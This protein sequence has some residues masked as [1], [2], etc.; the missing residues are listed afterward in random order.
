MLRGYVV[1]KFVKTFEKTVLVLMKFLLIFIVYLIFYGFFCKYSLELR[2]ISRVSTIV[3]TTFFV[4]CFVMIR[5]YGSIAFGKKT[6]K[7]LSLSIILSVIITDFFTYGQLCI[8]EKR[9]MPII[10]FICVIFAHIFTI[11]VMIKVGNNLFYYVNPPLKVVLICKE[12]DSSE[13]VLKKLKYYQNRYSVSKVLSAFSTDIYK[14]ID[15]ND[16]VILADISPHQKKKIIDYCYENEKAVFLLPD[17]SDMFLNNAQPE[18]FDDSLVLLKPVTGLSF[19][20][21]FLKRLSDII[22]SSFAIFLT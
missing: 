20:Q 16:G 1:L 11:F 12:M 2:R 14:C 9:V 13:S 7:E 18:F 17:F 15:I 4:V 22:I 10:I 21:R 19:E 5:L 3:T 8:M 6:T